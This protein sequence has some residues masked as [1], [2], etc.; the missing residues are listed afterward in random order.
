MTQI[1]D[2]KA[3]SIQVWNQ[4]NPVLASRGIDE[5]TWNALCTT[6]YPGAK[7]E[8]IIMAIDYCRSRDLDVMLK[9]VHLVPMNVKNAQTGN[10]EWR[11]V[12]MPGIGM[13]RIQSARSGNVAGIDEPIFGEMIT[14]VFKDKNGHDVSVTFPEWCSITVH[15]LMGDRIVSYVAKEYWIENYAS[16]GKNS[17]APNTMWR[18]RPRGQI[19]KCAEAQALRRGWPEVDQ[20]VTAEEMEG[21]TFEIEIN[22]VHQSKAADAPVLTSSLKARQAAPVVNEDLPDFIHQLQPESQ[23]IADRLLDCM[24]IE[25]LNA[26][27]VTASEKVPAGH[28]DCDEMSRLYN[29]RLTQITAK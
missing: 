8:S 6:I 26:W 19:A 5:S 14:K 24:T 11:D 7:P 1:I 17:E 2:Y 23:K 16:E 15:K 20:G 9:P 13:Y 18:K 28:P 29:E 27:G 25:D 4:A 3:N 21:K 10:Y 12:P 22:P